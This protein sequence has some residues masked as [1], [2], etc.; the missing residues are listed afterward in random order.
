MTKHTKY[1]RLVAALVAAAVLVSAAATVF[2][3][4]FPAARGALQTVFNP[5]AASEADRQTAQQIADMTG[6]SVY[7]L[8]EMKASMGSWNDVLASIEKNGIDHLDL[9]DEELK[10]RTDKFDEKDVEQAI[11]L[12]SRVVFNLREIGAKE[13]M[14]SVPE[15]QPTLTPS[16]APQ[17]GEYDFEKLEGQFLKNRAIWLVLE[18]QQKYGSF[19]KALDEYLYCLQIGVDFELVLTDQEEYENQLAQQGGQLLRED[20]ITVMIIEQH[21]LELMSRQ[22]S[23]RGE[24]TA[25]PPPNTAENA[26]AT[27]PELPAPDRAAPA[28]QAPEGTLPEVHNPVPI[29]PGTEVYE[30]IENIKQN[31]RPGAVRIG[32]EIQ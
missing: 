13:E 24:A 3:V 12:V 22:Q 15:I 31:S 9:T 2:A 26:D 25:P 6:S 1:K 7:Q 4:S 27:E 14:V 32:G 21:M 20:A 16:G 5:N 28:A 30:E 10:S 29:K 8:L 19:E 17:K 11:E 23:Q 18:T